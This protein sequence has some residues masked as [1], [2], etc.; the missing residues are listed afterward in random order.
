MSANG[1]IRF[2][3]VIISP[4]KGVQSY[5]EDDL[6]KASP[7]RVLDFDVADDDAF[8]RV[9]RGE[10]ETKPQEHVEAV[11]PKKDTNSSRRNRHPFHILPT[12]VET[13][14]RSSVETES[15][16][17]EDD[18]HQNL[19]NMETPKLDSSSSCDPNAST[20][21]LELFGDRLQPRKSKTFHSP[22]GSSV[23]QKSRKK[24]DAKKL[25]LGKPKS[26]FDKVK[27]IEEKALRQAETGR[28]EQAIRL[29][30]KVLRLNAAEISR[31][32]NQMKLVEGKHPN[33]VD[34]IHSRLREDWAKVSISTGNVQTLLA[35]LY[36]RLGDYRKAISSSRE[37]H[38][39]FKQHALLVDVVDGVSVQDLA[40]EASKMLQKMKDAQASFD[41]RKERHQKIIALRKKIAATGETTL[42][43]EV[44]A[45][46]ISVKEVEVATLGIS[47]PQ[48]ADTCL[49]LS[50]LALDQNH[51]E[52]AHKLA[53][54]ALCINESELGCKH[55]QTGKNL[56]Q[57]ARLHDSHN[58]EAA[59]KYYN[60]S[61][62]VFRPLD[63]LQGMVGSILN[64]IAIIHLR[65]GHFDLAIEALRGA[66]ESCGCNVA[67]KDA[68]ETDS[69]TA[70]ETVQVWRNLGECYFQKKEYEEASKSL[71]IALSLQR[72]VRR[73]HEAANQN[74]LG[75][76]AVDK[77]SP[78]FATDASIAE[79]L[80]RLGKA[81]RG[82]GRFQ[83]ATT[84]LRE[85]ILVHRLAVVKASSQ[86]KKDRGQANLSEKQD[87]LASSVYCLAE[88]CADM[89]DYDGATRLFG[90]TLQLRLFSDANKQGP[91]SNLIHCAMC[92]VGI[93]NIHV[94]KQEFKD[95]YKV[96]ADA[97]NYCDAHGKRN[98][99]CRYSN[100][101]ATYGSHLFLL[102][103]CS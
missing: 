25:V 64:N 92:L 20:V 65:R 93:G 31:I 96:F 39:T 18:F 36:E 38:F 73:V 90:D 98:I 54:E 56:L 35:T 95:A 37:A 41:D 27:E 51:R 79:T 57:I 63:V 49:V 47:H 88:V 55:P 82:M 86:A 81:Y 15:S 87:D 50:E 11:K 97:V 33:T 34:S 70:C 103:R 28:E 77:P 102:K 2:G 30:G 13:S 5:V 76:V 83:E 100:V 9:W 75:Q 3:T 85:A 8:D 48:V 84:V 12:L 17:A 71:V 10:E 42:L 7:T 101:L 16:S 46:V 4:Q 40:T 29:H 26:H 52:K 1:V 24:C 19:P 45:M 53:M 91:R 23:G 60:K 22:V 66:I 44:E 6:F 99:V 67:S 80:R 69:E 78:Y 89:Q 62:G 14:S 74:Q 58:D 21:V 59:L 43:K 72:D 32:Q 61:L 68:A 94:K